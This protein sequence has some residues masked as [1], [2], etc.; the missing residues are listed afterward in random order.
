MRCS[1]HTHGQNGLDFWMERITANVD[2]QPASG[3]EGAGAQSNRHAGHQSQS[4]CLLLEITA[5]SAQSSQRKHAEERGGTATSSCMRTSSG[6]ALM[7]LIPQKAWV[8]SS[9]WRSLPIRAI[10]DVLQT[11][12]Q[13]FIGPE[14]GLLRWASCAPWISSLIS[15]HGVCP[16]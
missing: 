10:L 14:E 13:R 16:Q 3:N 11:S 7:L 8:P 1:S 4:M 12:H 15:T 9:R 5:T 2:A 6:N